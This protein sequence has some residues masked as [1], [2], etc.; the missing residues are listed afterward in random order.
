[1]ARSVATGGRRE[2]ILAAATRAVE[3]CGFDAVRYSDVA[4]EAGVAVGTVQHY[5][6]SRGALLG[7]VFLEANREAIDNARQIAA[8]AGDDPW[9]RLEALVAELTGAA[10]GLWVDFWAAARRSDDLRA[11]LE[12]AYEAWRAPVVE[13]LDDGLA[14]GAFSSDFTASELGAA[15]VA[16]VD[17]LGLQRELNL[18]WLGPERSR[19]LILGTLSIA[20]RRR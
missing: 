11:V 4:A 14:G 18:S 19:E 6:A 8:A 5:Y 13:A 12:A 10:W 3:Q 15:L 1:M 9:H 17:G 16:M 2:Q 20:L 7:A